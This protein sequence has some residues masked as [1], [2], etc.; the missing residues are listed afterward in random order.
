MN[1]SY[2]LKDHEDEMCP[3][4]SLVRILFPPKAVLKSH[5]LKYEWMNK[6]EKDCINTLQFY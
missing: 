2:D 6:D 5:G 1:V 4:F 3:N